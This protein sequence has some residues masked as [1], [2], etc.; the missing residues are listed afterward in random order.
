LSEGQAG[1]IWV[2]FRGEIADYDTSPLRAAIIKGL[3]QPVC[4]EH[5]NL[6]NAAM[7]AR[8]RGLELVEEKSAQRVENFANLVGLRGSAGSTIQEVAGTVIEADPHIV[9]VDGYWVDV[10]PA[11]GYLLLTHHIDRPGLIAEVATIL[12]QAQLNVS[13]LKVGRRAVGGEAMM[14]L[15]VDEPIPP[16]VFQRIRGMEDVR[17]AKVARL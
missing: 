8:S 4:D 16:E 12:G 5:I 11:G 13:F 17:A 2:T 15:G 14:V 10:V 1:K 7:V 3:L 9:R 6:V